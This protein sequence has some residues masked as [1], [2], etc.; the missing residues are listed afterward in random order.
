M[1]NATKALII[2]G[3]I[4]VSILLVTMGITLLSG[5]NGLSDSNKN[6]MNE[7]DVRQF[8][9]RLSGGIGDSVIGSDVITMLETVKAMKREDSELEL[10]VTC[11]GKTD[12]DEII[13]TIKKTSRYSVEKTEDATTGLITA[14]TITK[15]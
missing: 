14:I 10:T 3:A 12:V 11:A 7:L 4:L 2:A 9:G 1:E 8:N 5:A 13:S 15:K 6:T